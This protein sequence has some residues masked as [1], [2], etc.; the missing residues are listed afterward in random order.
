MNGWHE[1]QHG[2]QLFNADGFGC[3]SIVTLR[4]RTISVPGK[5]KGTALPKLR[6]EEAPDMQGIS[7][8]TAWSQTENI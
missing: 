4:T 6:L 3:Q 2:G 5:T 8:C 7:V 1:S